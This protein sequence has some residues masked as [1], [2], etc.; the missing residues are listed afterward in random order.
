MKVIFSAIAFLFIIPAQ[1]QTFEYVYRDSKDSSSNC[2]LK[3]I[4]KVERIKGLIV[5]DFSSLPDTARKSPY[6]LHNLAAAN[7][8][9]TIYTVSSTYFPELYYDDSGPAILDEI[10]HE[11]LEEN[12]ISKENLFVGGISASGTRALRYAQYCEQEKSKY[13]HKVKGVFAVDS[14]LDLERFYNSSKRILARN[15]KN[16]SLEEA[17]LITTRFN[18]KMKGSPTEVP[19]NYIAASVFSYSD[20]KGGNAVHYTQLSIRLYHEP[21]IDWW[22]ENRGDSYYEINSVD[23][24]G[25]A[26]ELRIQ[27]NKN[28]ELITTTG[29]GFSR[30]GERKPHSWSIVDEEDLMHWIVEKMK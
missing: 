17:K 15:L 28:V 27:G 9:M 1:S 21:D 5:R 13:N 30:S 6:R 18:E 25:F 23:I 14:P 29:K 4:P 10:I 7:G 16:G 19:E 2:Y 11:V 20:L 8:I 12:T 22:M 24:A 26:N 3:V